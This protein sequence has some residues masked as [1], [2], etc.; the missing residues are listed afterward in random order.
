MKF[1]C[2]Q[3]HLVEQ[4]LQHRDVDFSNYFVDVDPG[5]LFP[6]YLSVSVL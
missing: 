5:K 6:V 3:G 1:L 2:R 4:V